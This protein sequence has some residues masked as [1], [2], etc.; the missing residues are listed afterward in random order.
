LNEG[1]KILGHINILC[2]EQIWKKRKGK[3]QRL[4]TRSLKG[5]PPP[6]LGPW[7]HRPR[8]REIR[9]FGSANEF[10]RRK[11]YQKG[12]TRIPHKSLPVNVFIITNERERIN[13][14]S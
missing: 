14:E 5:L 6:R 10:S 7:S 4:A 1:R 11:F 3:L 12:K 2:D 13:Y 8:E 9:M